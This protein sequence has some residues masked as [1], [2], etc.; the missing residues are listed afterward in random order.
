MESERKLMRAATHY[1]HRK[2]RLALRQWIEWKNFRLGRQCSE[3]FCPQFH[4]ARV[5]AAQRWYCHLLTDKFTILTYVTTRWIHM[6]DYGI[7]NTSIMYSI[8]III[9]CYYGYYYTTLLI[10][11][12][13]HQLYIPLYNYIAQVFL[14]HC[15]CLLLSAHNHYWLA[16]ILNISANVVNVAV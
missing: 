3:L 7:I 8:C 13:I 15:Y 9:I 2:M 6:V 4:D 10:L 5:S 14:L 12:H 16:M 1:A 11:W